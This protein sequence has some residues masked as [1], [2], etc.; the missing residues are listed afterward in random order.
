MS[1]SLRPCTP[2]DSLAAAN[3]TS[4]PVFIA[5]PSSLEGPVSGDAM[6][7][8]RSPCATG[9]GWPDGCT[10]EATF[11]P[12]LAP[13]MAA[14]P[15]PDQC[16]RSRMTP[17]PPRASAATTPRSSAPRWFLAGATTGG[18]GGRFRRPVC[19]RDPP[20]VGRG[21]GGVCSPV[22][23]A[24]LLRAPQGPLPLPFALS[25]PPGFP[26]HNLV[27]R[28]RLGAPRGHRVLV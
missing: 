2:P 22:T 1:C 19:G 26:R 13:P 11:T 23:A 6:P 12:S 8:R 7:K 18:L 9:A 3:A 17:G 16:E 21:G 10:T 20:G 27:S 24:F 15:S 25:S 4:T 28:L 5:R 14:G